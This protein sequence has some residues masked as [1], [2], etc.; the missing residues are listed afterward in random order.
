MKYYKDYCV[1]AK[2]MCDESIPFN[3]RKEIALKI[4]KLFE[5]MEE[6]GF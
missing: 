4:C 5:Y 1:L 3:K 2:M 6:E